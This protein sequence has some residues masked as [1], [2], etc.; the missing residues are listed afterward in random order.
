ML[1]DIFRHLEIN[2]PGW[3]W[4]EV[5]LA[6]D[7]GWFEPQ[8]LPTA[9]SREASVVIHKGSRPC[10]IVPLAESWAQTARTLKRNVRESIRRGTNRLARDDHSW[11]LAVAGQDIPMNDA[12]E[13][14]VNLQSAARPC[15]PSRTT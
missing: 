1:R 15:G 6:P 12:L 2:V 11:R 13:T 14:L 8:W 9:I 3:D 4:L 7:Q 5:T 10:V